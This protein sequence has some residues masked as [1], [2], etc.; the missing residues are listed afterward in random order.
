MTLVRAQ[1]F[2]KSFIDRHIGRIYSLTA[3]KVILICWLVLK[4]NQFPREMIHIKIARCLAPY[5]KNTSDQGLRRRGAIQRH[6]AA[7]D[8][9]IPGPPPLLQIQSVRAVVLQVPVAAA[10]CGRST[11][12]CRAR[13]FKAYMPHIT[14]T[15]SSVR[16][17]A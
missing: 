12:W 16:G 14:C 1:F 15:T 11:G 6:D 13:V 2:K 7:S 5:S 3:A 9:C 4:K 17:G 8:I 10:V